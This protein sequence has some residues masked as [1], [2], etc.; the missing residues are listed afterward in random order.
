[1]QNHIL[2]MKLCSCWNSLHFMILQNMF[3]GR[4]LKC[5][6][7]CWI[8]LQLQ[9]GFKHGTWIV[10]SR[11]VSI[12]PN[13]QEYYQLRNLLVTTTPVQRYEHWI[14]CMLHEQFQLNSQYLELL[15]VTPV[16]Y[17]ENV[18]A[19]QDMDS[20]VY[21]LTT[22]FTKP[23]WLMLWCNCTF[24]KDSGLG[25]LKCNSFTFL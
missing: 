5:K 17:F 24:C 2:Q 3:H 9:R 8:G 13:H 25:K 12:T 21:S 11:M 22:C 1:M 4:D 23:Y 16:I 20:S 18:S 19:L 14:P 10:H 6:S 7:Y 15:F